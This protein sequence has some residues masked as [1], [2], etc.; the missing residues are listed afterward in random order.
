MCNLL[1][2]VILDSDAHLHSF[3]S[4]IRLQRR[5]RNESSPLSLNYPALV[6]RVCAHNIWGPLV[7]QSADSF[8]D[9]RTLHDVLEGTET[10]ALNFEASHILHD[11]FQILCEPLVHAWECRRLVLTGSHFRWLPF[12]SSQA[13][14]TFLSNITHLTLWIPYDD[15]PALSD[16]PVPSWACRVPFFALPSLSHL[17]FPL[18]SSLPLDDMKLDF[19]I[20]TPRV[21]VSDALEKW[22]R[23]ERNTA[24]IEK[25]ILACDALRGKETSL[26]DGPYAHVLT[27]RVWRVH[28]DR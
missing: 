9:H 8:I 4:A 26:W 23:G 22:S 7:N 16:L 20:V 12:T 25:F 1:H 28:E 10:L 6:R 21:G 2:T 11:G 14:M 3:V 24:H 27:E 5:H 19:Y 13:G 15:S 17:A 18:W